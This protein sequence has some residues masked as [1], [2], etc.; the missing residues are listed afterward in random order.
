MNTEGQNATDLIETE[1]TVSETLETVEVPVVAE[2]PVEAPAAPA[3]AV[4]VDDSALYIHRELS[5][6]QFNIR[7]LEQALDESYPLLERLKFLL[8]FSSNLDEF[9]EI[10]V[11]GLKK[12]ITFAREQ[13]GADGL[14]PHQ[15][16]AR[17]SEQ[18]HEQVGR[19]YAILND[20][21][22]PEL[23]KHGVRFIRRRYWTPKIKAWV[24]RFFRDEI[25]PIITPIGL[26]P[27][28]PF[29]LLVN[30]SLN[31]VVEL[32][33]MDA[34]GRDSGLAII[35]APRSLPRIIRL[36][37][38]VAGEGDNYVFLSSMIHAHADDLFSGMK[39]K[40]CY[41][42]RL[43]RNADLSVD[44]E[45]VEDL[46]RAL[47]G[48]LFSRRYGDAVRLEVVDTCPAH[49]SNYLLKQFGLAE[50]ELYKV[51]GPVNLTRLFSV[52][53]LASHP[54]LQYPPFTPTIPKLLQKKENM[55]GV[56]AKLDVLLMHPFESF[57]PVVD[58]LRQAAK[59]PNVLAIKQ[60]LYRSGANSEIVDALVEAARNGKEVTAVI[61]LRARFDEESNLQLASRLQQAGAV[62]IYGVVGF[63]THAKMML[64]LRREDGE[65]RRY[66]HLGTGNYHAGNAR[67]YTDY[68][69][70]TA[71]VA[72]C[73]DLHKL[74]N[75]LIGMGKT[76]R[77]KKLLHAP[78][79][80]KKNLLEM[81]NREAAQAAEGKPAHIMAKVNSLTDPKVI[82][83]LYKASQA[84]VKIDLVVRGMCCLRPGVP[85][86]SHNIQVRSIIGRFLEHSRIYYFLN[87]GDEKLYLS[88][89]DWMERNL[90]MR[91]ETCFP[92]EGKKLVQRVKKELELY[93]ADNTQAWVLQ[94]DGSY[95]RLNPTGNQNPRNAQAMLLER[96]CT[97]VIS[98]R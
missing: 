22:L 67:L 81:I 68:S 16:L 33:G 23:A 19:Q 93:L 65:L 34:F 85:G 49:L 11:A 60:T 5:Q 20:I 88:S 95:Q 21:L 96:L 26:D 46:A 44:A 32:E 41:Q 58:L 74:F 52:T 37:E 13:A 42:F 78:F 89:A 31:F 28:H 59:D 57:T 38:D 36:P 53:G 45:D 71:D 86:V 2:P 82:R 63:K 70:L 76:L 79:T 10:R 48:E 98:A 91:V 1:V 77:M 83:A 40:G 24:R 72:L 66:A 61:E 29:P 18:V 84:G 15:A 87:G 9:F 30:K 43:T 97:P 14:L 56:L 25:A 35:P 94:P 7:V 62:V 64:I 47:R 54:E 27:T 51:S 39:V 55:F 80:L 6:L 3:V 73:E 50:S 92:V 75:Q 69:L 4:N 90:D 12:Q 8:I 17:I